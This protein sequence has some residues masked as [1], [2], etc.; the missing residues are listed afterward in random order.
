MISFEAGCFIMG[1][2]PMNKSM[3]NVASGGALRMKQVA[4]VERPYLFLF[5]GV[6]R[7]RYFY[8]PLLP[9]IS[10]PATGEA[11]G[12]VFSSIVQLTNSFALDHPTMRFN[13]YCI[14]CYLM[15]HN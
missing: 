1:L 6:F 8:L 4:E 5:D 9:L 3:I 14:L 15:I 7:F 13:H 11:S 2:L 10:P 12:L